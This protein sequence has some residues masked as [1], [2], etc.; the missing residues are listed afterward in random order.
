MMH[1]ASHQ[2]PHVIGQWVLVR[3]R[4]TE[5]THCT[6]WVRSGFIEA[7][8]GRRGRAIVASAFN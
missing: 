3:L 2:G 1:V 7:G 4:V 8:C 6:M 5:G